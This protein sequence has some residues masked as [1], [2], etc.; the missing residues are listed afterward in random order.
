MYLLCLLHW[1]ISGYEFELQCWRSALHECN[2]TVYTANIDQKATVKPQ[3]APISISV[4]FSQGSAMLWGLYRQLLQRVQIRGQ[5]PPELTFLEVKKNPEHKPN[6]KAVETAS[7]IIK[8]Q[9]QVI[10]LC[11]P[12]CGLQPVWESLS[13]WS[14]AARSDSLAVCD[15]LINAPVDMQKLFSHRSSLNKER[16][17][18]GSELSKSIVSV[19]LWRSN[20]D[21][22]QMRT[23]H[24]S[25]VFYL[26]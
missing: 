11:Q 13:A 25:N 14:A 19:F 5:L 12:V 2:F 26:L 24:H 16:G 4:V 20:S 15:V 8:L 21:F 22:P 10:C 18:R 17:A 23:W 3:C 9:C 1:Y 6:K 7:I